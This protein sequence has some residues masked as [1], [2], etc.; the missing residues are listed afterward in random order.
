MA[1]VSAG[2]DNRFGHPSSDVLDR[3]SVHV[4]D[5]LL[6]QTIERGTVHI[7]TDGERWWASAERGE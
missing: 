5:G 4:P 7:T 1:V 2:A 3:L 6:F